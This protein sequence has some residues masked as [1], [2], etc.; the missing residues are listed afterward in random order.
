MRTMIVVDIHS[1]GTI[2]GEAMIEYLPYVAWLI[3]LC[4][5]GVLAGYFI[6][7]FRTLKT[8]N[9]SYDQHQE[10]RI[11]NKATYSILKHNTETEGKESKW[12]PVAKEWASSADPLNHDAAK[13]FRDSLDDVPTLSGKQKLYRFR[14]WPPSNE[15]APQV[16]SSMDM[17]PPPNDEVK[18]GGRYNRARHAVLYLCTSELGCS[19]ERKAWKRQS[20]DRVIFI[21]EYELCGDGL[22][23]AD[24]T[25]L[26]SV[27]LGTWVMFHA[28]DCKINDRIVQNEHS[29]SF[30]Q[31]VAEIVFSHGFDGMKVAGTRGDRRNVGTYQNVVVFD[32]HKDRQWTSW[33]RGETKLGRTGS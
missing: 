3:F 6:V 14:P 33:L 7:H 25:Q 26:A 27:D 1:T 17:G 20:D 16:P 10:P 23:I 19:L 21:Q 22:K 2:Q 8:E 24:F 15:D 9:E 12:T 11:M 5:C 31:A 29:Y 28:E 32:P 30:S 13:Q 18:S 4:F